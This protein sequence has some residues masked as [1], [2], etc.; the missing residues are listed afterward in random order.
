VKPSTQKQKRPPRL[1]GS[2]GCAP[3]RRLVC[4]LPADSLS[5]P[6]RTH[7]EEKMPKEVDAHVL[8]SCLG[9]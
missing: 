2:H 6:V 7:S 3:A 8:V 1:R 4:G 5:I 9:P